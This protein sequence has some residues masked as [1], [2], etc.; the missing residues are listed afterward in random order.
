[1]CEVGL[2]LY[3]ITLLC[4]WFQLA[5]GATGLLMVRSIK[6]SPRKSTGVEFDLGKVF[7]APG[8]LSKSTV[9]NNQFFDLQC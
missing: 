1:M 4:G 9:V 6:C 3:S 2:G 7:K 8:R 5:W